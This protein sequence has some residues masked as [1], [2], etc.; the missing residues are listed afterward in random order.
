M[1]IYEQP[2]IQITEIAP[3]QELAAFGDQNLPLSAIVPKA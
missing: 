1:K 2:Q 3:A